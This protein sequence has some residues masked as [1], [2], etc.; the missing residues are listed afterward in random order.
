MFSFSHEWFLLMF[1][2]QAVI[3]AINTTMAQAVPRYFETVADR[4]WSALTSEVSFDDVE[5]YSFVGEP[6]PFAFADD[7]SGT[8]ESV[9][10]PAARVRRGSLVLS[11]SPPVFGSPFASANSATGSFHSYS[12]GSS[13]IG[14]GVSDVDEDETTDVA[15]DDA[16]ALWQHN[17]F[18]YDRKR[19]RILCW[20]AKCLPK[21]AAETALDADYED[22]MFDMTLDV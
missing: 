1:Y 15:D 17:Y 13:G 16:R 7:T 20:S 22:N 19:K 10:S 9:S 21:S 4:F 14:G 5:A 2:C 12:A 8:V 11:S 18:L 3:T 6:N